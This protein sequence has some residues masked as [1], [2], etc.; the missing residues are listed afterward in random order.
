M[1]SARRSRI[2]W[3][4]LLVAWLCVVWGHSLM[5]ADLSSEESSRFV[6][7]VRPLFEAFG[8]AD[9]GLMTHAIRKAAHF[10][11]NVVLML[12]ATRFARVWQ[13]DKPAARAIMVAIWVCV[14]MV[15][16]AIQ[17]FSPG[18]SPQV[19]DVL[20]DMGGGLAYPEQCR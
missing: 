6:F 8:C 4:S 5:P 7:L 14:P 19:T 1:T 10:S 2:V 11:E 17:S 13:A 16:E 3:T 15:D 20:L 18:R 12:I 9:E